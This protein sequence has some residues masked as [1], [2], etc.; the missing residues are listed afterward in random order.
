MKNKI[1]VGLMFV[2]LAIFTACDNGNAEVGVI[3]GPPTIDI[4]TITGAV[5]GELLNIPVSFTDGTQGIA[6]STL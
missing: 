1:Y 4:G 6:Q 2:A 3:D 5:E